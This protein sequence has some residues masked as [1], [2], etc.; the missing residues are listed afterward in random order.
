MS[1]N[2]PAPKLPSRQ[3][4]GSPRRLLQQVLKNVVQERLPLVF[5]QEPVSPVERQPE[6]RYPGD[7][8]GREGGALASRATGGRGITRDSASGP[9]VL[10]G[11]R[12]GDLR[13]V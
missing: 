6:G 7:A 1:I 10:G 2:D 13:S 5:L 12:D 4:S 11:G 3:E 9:D 8:C